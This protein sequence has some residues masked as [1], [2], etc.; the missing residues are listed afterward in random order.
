MCRT[1]RS[2]SKLPPLHAALNCVSFSKQFLKFKCFDVKNRGTHHS[3]PAVMPLWWGS[4]VRPKHSL[5]RMLNIAVEM[6]PCQ[7]YLALIKTEE[8]LPLLDILAN[9]VKVIR[10]LREL[11]TTNLPPGTFPVKVAIPVVPTISVLV[12]FTKFEELQPLD[13]F[14]TPPLSPRVAGN[15][16]PKIMMQLPPGSLISISVLVGLYTENMDM[17]MRLIVND[18]DSILN[19]LTREIKEVGPDGKEVTKLVPAVSDEIK[20]ALLIN[21]RRRMTLQPLKIQADIEMKCFQMDWVLHIKAGMRKAEA[22]GNEDCPVKMIA[23]HIAGPL[24]LRASPRVR[25]IY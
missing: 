7:M 14:S 2:T 15:E 23:L 5:K 1:F 22:A 24:N 9:K 19:S 10:R 17:H 11:L 25:G 4:S 13:E 12:T 3:Y 16:S 21:I 20:D 6:I 8:L 18:P